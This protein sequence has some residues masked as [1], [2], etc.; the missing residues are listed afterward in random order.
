MPFNGTAGAGLPP[1]VAPSPAHFLH[2]HR[3]H[4]HGL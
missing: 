2:H 3:R 1:A 4:S